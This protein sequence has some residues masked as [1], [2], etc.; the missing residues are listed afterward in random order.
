MEFPEQLPTFFFSIGQQAL[1]RK[2]GKRRNIPEA[3]LCEL[4]LTSASGK[5][6][7]NAKQFVKR[8]LK[9][10]DEITKLFFDTKIVDSIDLGNK[11]L[12][13]DH[14]ILGSRIQKMPDHFLKMI[15][16]SQTLEYE[17]HGVGRRSSWDKGIGPQ[18]QQRP[19]GES[20]KTSP[21]LLS[22][23]ALPPCKIGLQEDK[24]NC[25]D[26][27]FRAQLKQ[28]DLIT[29]LPASSVWSILILDHPFCIDPGSASQREPKKILS[30]HRQT[31]T[32]ALRG[33][34]SMLLSLLCF[35]F[36]CFAFPENVHSLIWRFSPAIMSYG[37]HQGPRTQ[38][39]YQ[40]STIGDGQVTPLNQT[41][42]TTPLCIMCKELKY[43]FQQE[44]LTT[45]E[46]NAEL[47]NLAFKQDPLLAYS[48][49][50]TM[51]KLF[52]NDPTNSSLVR[53]DS[54]SY[55]TVIESLCQ[56]SRSKM[57]LPESISS[58]AEE[59]A[60]NAAQH[61]L[62]SM[63]GSQHMVP[64]PL[65]YLFVC[66]KW[67]GIDDSTGKNMQKAEGILIAYKMKLE[68]TNEYSSTYPRGSLA[69]FYAV[70]VDGW[71]RLVGKVDGALDRA[72]A[73][74]SDLESSC[75]PGK[76]QGFADEPVVQEMRDE[77]AKSH[78]DVG[79]FSL[80]YTSYIVGISR[81]KQNDLGRQADA[82]L[83]RM[84]KNGVDP[85][86]VV[87]TS[88]LN[89][90]AKA[91][92]RFERQL[93]ST[94]AVELLEEIES[95]YLAEENYLL[96]PSQITYSQAIKAIGYS[97][98]P[99]A[100][101]LAED[102]LNRMYELTQSKKINVPP[103]VHNYNAVITALS[104]GGGNDQRGRYAEK[105]EA[106]LYKMVRYSRYEGELVEPSCVTYGIVLKAWAES[107][108][109]DCGEQAQRVLDQFEEWY[110]N[111]NSRV[112][113][114]VVCYTTVMQAWGR[115]K[116]P[117]DVAL[118]NVEK[119]LTKLENLYL[120][121]GS[122]ALRPN[123]ITY[124]TAMDV[125]CRKC[126]EK[127]GSM[128]QAIV[129]RMFQLHE[130]GIGYEKPTCMVFNSLINAWSKN[131]EK[132]GAENAERAFQEMEGRYAAGDTSAQPD[133]VSLCNVLN[134]WANLGLKGGALRA[135]Q[136]MDYTTK[137]LTPQ[138]RGFNHTVVSWNVLIKAWG[139]SR[140]AD[141]VDRAEKILVDLETQYERGQS[142]VKPDITTYSSVI[143]CCAYYSGPAKS[144]SAAFDVALRTFHKIKKSKD[145]FAN[146]IVY[147][148]LFK[149]IG[150]LQRAGKGRDDMI[151][152]LFGE[153]CR[154][155]QVCTFSLA[156]VRSASSEKLFRR[157][158]LKACS[159]E[160]EEADNIESVWR[161]LPRSWKRNVI[162]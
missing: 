153:C 65:N 68:C 132:V 16:T 128:S 49:L 120:E 11:W 119:I 36:L 107:G 33:S 126:P 100:P 18:Y 5:K 69:A 85:D 29:K 109:P 123:Q 94:R 52:E 75:S 122:D 50:S 28:S 8:A 95:R 139:R 118:Q 70:L 90:W 61:L 64:S 42:N 84:V 151:E 92:T 1:R 81:S 32:T 116:G 41:K 31:P 40:Y 146:S 160:N 149:A 55:T 43:D 56:P 134:A 71:S 51:E 79:P 46:F 105:A 15:L 140:A 20:K 133:E 17:L 14:F 4:F 47:H 76:D 159:L 93:A 129:D 74:L 162:C 58:A 66:Q 13:V 83:K 57:R 86:M 138:Q 87:Y 35:T 101:W 3:S 62:F 108:R 10:R 102:I 144:K 158:V 24:S 88:V 103:N 2:H 22:L 53:P 7:C 157:L 44:Y 150:K 110:D 152:E 82:V 161:K 114:N 147:G 117:P 30:P 155:G 21:T 98:D 54:I 99:N 26:Q 115:G 63:E 89:C 67:A 23:I 25:H 135:Q 45:K 72:D 48:L 127:A 77:L 145:L 148:T 73:L 125:Y 78:R 111:G 124:I 143:N 60:A 137:S 121:T 96:K 12:D 131:P 27:R 130:I 97:L 38:L 34:R 19:R 6:A 142:S 59:E 9:H 141:A 106:I 154:A 104:T 156:Q 136:I 80:A 112:R 113:P 39:L 91:R 37:H